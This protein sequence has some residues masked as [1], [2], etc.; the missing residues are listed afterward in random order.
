LTLVEEGHL[1]LDD[2]VERYLPEFGRVSV[3]V[4]DI[5]ATT[6]E[7]RLRLEPPRRAMTVHDLLRHTSGLTYG[8]FGDSLVQRLYRD[9]RLL[10]GQQTNAQMV[11][12][13]ATLP[14][15]C[16]PGSTFEYGMSTDVVGPIIEV[17]SGMDLERFIVDRIA[18]PLEMHSTA[19]RLIERDGAGLALPRRHPGAPKGVLFD[20]D[21][22]RPP[23]WFSG[24]AG[25][26]S[27]AGDY[28]RFCQMLLNGGV[29]DG[30][31]LLS[32]K[33]IELMLSDHLPPNTGY[34]SSTTGLGI[35][36]PLRELGQGH[37]LCVGVRTAQGLCPVPGSVGDFFWGGALGTYFWA[38]PREQLIGILML[39]ENDMAT[40]A[41]YRT[42]LR[43]VAYG[44]L[45]D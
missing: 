9:H 33:S 42:F 36:A 11:T 41:A 12:K 32:R 17:V 2:R 6:G 3:G 23:T 24:G 15:Q 30:V 45:Q 44:A 14:L 7:R 37:G 34:G 1:A 39:Q 19:F 13:L 40:R 16:Q 20:Y 4:E 43:N 25:L 35:N 5:D 21:A 18:R 8:P 26:L 10:D 31:R 29:L 27:T 22:A 38:D 28:A